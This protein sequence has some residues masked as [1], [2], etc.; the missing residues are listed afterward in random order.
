MLLLSKMMQNSATV[1]KYCM[2][3]SNKDEVPAKKK[4]SKSL[5]FVFSWKISVCI[6]SFF[7]FPPLQ[8]YGFQP[9]YNG[10]ELSC[11]LRNLRRSTSYKFRVCTI[12]YF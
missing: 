5:Y 6:C 4:K 11:T 10:D 7:F 3:L 9:Q 2:Y 1:G 12:F 8:G